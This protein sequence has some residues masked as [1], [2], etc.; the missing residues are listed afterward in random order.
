MDW[1]LGMIAV[2]CYAAGFSSFALAVFSIAA[3]SSIST[4]TLRLRSR[5]QG[6]LSDD[7]WIA[8]KLFTCLV[9]LSAVWCLAAQTGLLAS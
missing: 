4:I 2:L 5:G 1:V 6:T 8:P 7:G 9:L 3:I